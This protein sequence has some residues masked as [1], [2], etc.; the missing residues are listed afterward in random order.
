MTLQFTFDSLMCVFLTK[1]FFFHTLF[2]HKLPG[3]QNYKRE[4]M[5]MSSAKIGMKGTD[6]IG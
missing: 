6:P 3:A 2:T 1:P 4:N 5:N